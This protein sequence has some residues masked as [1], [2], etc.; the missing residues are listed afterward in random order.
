MRINLKVVLVCLCLAVFFITI[1]FWSRCGDLSLPKSFLPKWDSRRFYE[2]NQQGE[3]IEEIECLINQKYSVSCRREGD[4]VYLP[5]SFLHDYFEVF[6]TISSTVKGTNRFEW[7]H[8]NAKVNYP[9]EAYDPKGIF[10]YFENYNVEMRDRV[11]CISA[12]DGVPLSTQWQTQAYY[13]PTQIAQFGLSHY[14]KNLTDP[15]PRKKIIEDAEKDQSEW[16]VPKGSNLTRQYDRSVY[17]NVVSYTTPSLYESAVMLPLDHVLDLVMS[18]DILLKVNSSSLIV[19]LQNRETKKTFNLHYIVADL[20]LSIQG[21]NFYY[22]IGSNVNDWKHLTRDL[23]V[24]LQ[25]GIQAQSNS[26]KKKKHRRTEI[27]VVG[28]SF[29]GTGSFDNLTF[30]TSEHIAQFY[31]AAEWFV[32]HQD[33]SGG[34]PNPV[35]RKLSEFAELKAGWYSAMGQGHAISLLSRA[36]HHSNGDQRYLKAAVD[37]LKPF[38]VPSKQ[39]GVLAKFLGKLDWYEEYPTSPP[40]FVLNGFIY[41]LLGLYDLNA[42]VPALQSRDAGRLYEQGMISLKK[43]LLLFDTGSGTIYDLRHF[44]LG[45]GPN[46]ARWDYHATHVNQLLLLAKI[47]QDPLISRTAE[48]WHSY[49]Y[50]KRSPHN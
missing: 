19:M 3:S 21:E 50:G 44:T 28:I 47:H 41:S 18:V 25:K 16:I 23:L 8:T 49:M 43:M 37:G 10:M 13:Y 4:E 6:G 29:L 26:D 27:K 2:G 5:F 45:I 42:T 39:G 36:Y 20:M 7:S 9:K 12:S 14:S 24:D 34:W 15:E 30:S 31:D 33:S 48:R 11:K 38:R 35:K 22:G 46:I 32:R 1:T 40:S 17:S